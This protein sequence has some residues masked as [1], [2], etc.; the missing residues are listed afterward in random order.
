[1]SSLVHPNLLFILVEEIHYG[2][3]S[4][5]RH[6]MMIGGSILWPLGIVVRADLLSLVGL[7]PTIGLAGKFFIAVSNMKSSLWL[8]LAVLVPVRFIGGFYNVRIAITLFRQTVGSGLRE[9]QKQPLHRGISIVPG[10]LI[11]LF[12]FF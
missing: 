1:M 5:V 8:P 7:P 10:E 12:Q 11:S 4:V 6:V 9:T 2:M 3:S